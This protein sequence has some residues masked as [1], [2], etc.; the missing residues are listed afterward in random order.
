M[1]DARPVVLITGAS[2]GVGKAVAAEMAAH[3]YDAA[4]LYRSNAA[5]VEEAASA[6]RTAGGKAS[7]IQADLTDPQ[8]VEKAVADTIAHFGQIDVLAHCAGAYTAWKP[9]RSLTAQEWTGLSRCRPVRFLLRSR[10]LCAP[11]ARA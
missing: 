1:T 5:S 9:I 2:G 3:G 7:V 6:V 10:G 4:L 8:A 11:Y